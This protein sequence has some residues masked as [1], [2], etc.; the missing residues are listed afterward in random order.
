MLG[1][2]VGG[3]VC[4][5]LTKGLFPHG[6]ERSRRLWLTLRSWGLF[7]ELARLFAGL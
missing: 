1:G 2:L 6:E 3:S 4:R 5:K 7:R